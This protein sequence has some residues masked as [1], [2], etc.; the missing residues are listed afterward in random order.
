MELTCSK[1][2]LLTHLGAENVTSARFNPQ[3]QFHVGQL[4]PIASRCRF[5]DIAKSLGLRRIFRPAITA[6]ILCCIF[7]TEQ[8]FHSLLLKTAF[9]RVRHKQNP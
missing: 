5:D 6:E 8:P 7:V 4:E 2:I 1:P 9:P 3:R